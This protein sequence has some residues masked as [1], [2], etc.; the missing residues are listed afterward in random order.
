MK[1]VYLY[2]IKRILLYVLIFFLALTTF[3]FVLHLAP[4]DPVLRYVQQMQSRFGYDTGVTESGFERFREQFGLDK[5][6]GQRYLSFI[7][8][9][10]LKGNFGPSIVSYPVPAQRLIVRALPWTIGL[11]SV[12]VILS[13]VLGMILGTFIG[14]R[15]GTTFERVMTPLALIFSQ[16]PI[17][18]MALL[19]AMGFVYGI[20]IFPAGGAYSPS[21]TGS[22]S[23]RYL[24]S[25]VYHALLPAFS[26]VIVGLFMWGLT[27]RALVINL[28]GEDYMRLGEAKGLPTGRLAYRY[29]LRNTLLPQATGLALSLGFVVNGFFLIEWIFRYPGIGRLFIA[30]IRALDYNVLLGITV[31]SMLMV[32]LAN[33]IVELV[34]PLIDP[35]I[36]RGET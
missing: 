11:L 36:R 31:I 24:W 22:F 17:Y 34:Y 32:L 13:W 33:L 30:S 3:F 35:R 4:G 12:S 18:L 21:L 8:E 28:L 9:L 19:L 29:V 20:A 14:W 27:Q 15:R 23:L 5:P 25:I 6:L 10:L 26:Q 1:Q 2:L 16:M 7:R